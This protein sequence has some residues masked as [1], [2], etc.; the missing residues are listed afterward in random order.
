MPTAGVRELSE[1]RPPRPGALARAA[2]VVGV[3]LI[4]VL[5]PP[6]GV[7]ARAVAQNKADVVTLESLLDRAGAYFLSFENRFSDVVTEERYVQEALRPGSGL[8]VA[9][10]RRGGFAPQIPPSADRREL[11]SDFLLVKLPNTDEWLP[12]RDVFEVDNRRVRDREDRLSKLFLQ[13][14][15]T[16]LAQAQRIM[17]E[18]ARYNIGNIQRTINLPVFA[19]EVLRPSTQSRFR[20]SRGKLDTSVGANV[21]EVDYRE[22]SSPTLIHGVFGKDLF[23]HGRFWI[24]ATTGRVLKSELLV[25]DMTVHASIT[26]RYQVDQEHDLAVPVDMKEDYKLPNGYRVTG[27]A[28][29]GRFRR[30]E[31]R[32]A[33]EIAAPPR[34]ITDALTGMTLVEVPQGRLSMG[35]PSSEAGRGDDE[36]LHEVTIGRPFLLGRFEVTQEQWRTV[37]I[38]S[39]SQFAGCVS[40]CPVERVS[41]E[42]V[43][44]FLDS[45]NDRAS[46]VHYRLPTEA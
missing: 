8:D 27:V 22:Q 7:T 21:Y 10:T 1:R 16:A 31:V 4:V 11:V 6:A 14:A 15:P 45:L 30:F 9:V 36:S 20:F 39:P 34:T 5:P 43:Q 33:D 40:T 3:A 37:M 42:E 25:D 44:Q 13:P 46:G 19:L 32:V 2:T 17:E 38:S 26:A 35:S 12:F 29:Y 24:E 41:F 23:S 18:S 28:T